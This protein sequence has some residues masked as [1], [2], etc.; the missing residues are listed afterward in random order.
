MITGRRGLAFHHPDLY[1]DGY[2]PA[3]RDLFQGPSARQRKLSL[4]CQLPPA[5]WAVNLA[6]MG[7]GAGRSVK[8]GRN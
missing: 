8:S 4:R 2:A 1:G 3:A 6:K 7:R 5:G